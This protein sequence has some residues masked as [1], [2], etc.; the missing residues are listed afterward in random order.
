MREWQ[1]MQKLWVCPK[2]GDDAAKRGVSKKD[3]ERRQ[4]GL[5]SFSSKKRVLPR[6]GCGCWCGVVEEKEEGERERQLEL[7]GLSLLDR[8]CL[9]NNHHLYRSCQ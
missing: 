4:P 2:R 3:N 5:T 8:V 1:K 7:G 9:N 6:K